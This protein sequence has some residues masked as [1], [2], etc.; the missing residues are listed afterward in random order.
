MALRTYSPLLLVWLA[1]LLACAGCAPASQSPPAIPVFEAQVIDDEISI[2]YGLA[3]GHVDRDNKP[4]ILLADKN[5]FAWY[6]NG[7]W[8]RHVLIENL[9]ERDNVALAARDI[10]GDGRVEIAVGAMWNPGETTDKN[11]SGAVY[12]LI[13]PPEPTMQWEPVQLPHDPTTHRMQWVKVG[14]TA[15]DLVVL[16]LH[17]IGNSSGV[18]DGVHI[19]AYTPPANP[20]DPWKTRV[21]DDN[22]H[23]T[24]NFDVVEREDAAVLYVAGKEG[25]RQIGFDGHWAN[26][27]TPLEGVNSAA[28]EVRVGMLVDK[29][30]VATIEP[31]HGNKLVAYIGDG[32]RQ[33]VVLDTTFAQGHALAVADVLGLG[34]DQIVAGWRNPDANDQVGIRLYIP[35][36]TGSSWSI[37]L[38]DENTMACEDLKVADLNAD[39]KPDIIA[40]GRAT[41]NLVV[42]WNKSS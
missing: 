37:F 4:D 13:Q 9:T 28:G 31:M 18:G 3:I 15:Y 16:P 21:L 17:G 8:D 27:A 36:E 33:R 12:Y 39:G 14:E 42:Y 1:A 30:L 23:L 25:V 22:M 5:Q 34:R 6:R 11:M 41:R 26:A 10:D 40:A 19:Q 20:R 29:P 35:D 38:I 32:E 7:T 24:H 2:G